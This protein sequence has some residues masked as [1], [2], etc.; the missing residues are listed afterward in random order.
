VDLKIQNLVENELEAAVTRIE[1]AVRIL[2]YEQCRY[3]LWGNATHHQDGTGGGQ[4]DHRAH[5]NFNRE[6]A[7]TE[8]TFEVEALRSLSCK[9]IAVVSPFPEGVNRR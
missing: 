2:Q 4:T 6:A 8:P 3:L 1:E 9:R 5:R 7:T